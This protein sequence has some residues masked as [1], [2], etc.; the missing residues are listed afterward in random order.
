MDSFG[1]YFPQK[2]YISIAKRV[3]EVW[4][5]YSK[6]PRFLFQPSFNPFPHAL[7]SKS[8]DFLKKELQKTLLI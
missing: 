2:K 7:S 1:K 5:S 6:S 3:D 8:V 4:P